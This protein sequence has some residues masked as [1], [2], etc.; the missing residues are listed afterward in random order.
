MGEPQRMPLFQKGLNN[1]FFFATF[2]ALSFQVVLGSP[3]VLYAKSLGASATVLGIISGMMPLLVIFQIPAANY[4]PRMG[5]KRFVYGGWGIRVLLIFVL[6]LVPLLWRVLTP[7]TQL[8][9]VLFLLFGFNLSRGISSA[10]W[11]PWITSL[12]P[13]SIRGKYLATEAGFVNLASGATF[14]IAAAVLGDAPNAVDFAILFAFSGVAGAIS[15]SFLKR[16]PDVQPAQEAA[17]STHPVPWGTLIRYAPFLKLLKMNVA[18]SFA[19]GGIGAFSVAYLKVMAGMPEGKILYISSA[20]FLGGLLSLAFGNRMDKLGSKPVMTFSCILWCG[21]IL[22]WAGLAGKT[23]VPSLGVVLVLHFGMG[24]AVA[25]FNMAN[26]RLAMGIAPEMGRNHFFAVFSVVANL[27]L[28]LAPICWGLLID[29][30]RD[31]QI[32]WGYFELNRYS[33][34]FCGAGIMFLLTW[35]KIRQLEEPSAG[36]VQELVHQILIEGPQ[37]VVNRLWSRFTQ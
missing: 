32:E 17:G 1:A 20:F 9:L 10:A 6:S 19:Y 8:A 29:I 33:L 30:F 16:I 14:L 26:V 28:G 12:V 24:L 34:F 21:L 13:A 11:L 25:L 5:Y 31:L 2:N 37:R 23:I 7:M 18:W 15:L 22:F 4:I 35:W 27:T 3:M 36:K